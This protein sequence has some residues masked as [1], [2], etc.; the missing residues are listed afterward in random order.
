MSAAPHP[1]LTAFGLD[2]HYSA[3]AK[4]LAHTGSFISGGA[5]LYWKLIL[6]DS[7]VTVPDDMDIDIWITNSPSTD[8]RFRCLA[9]GHFELVLGAA[10]YV[11]Q[12]R[13]EHADYMSFPGGNIITYIQNFFHHGLKRNIQIIAVSSPDF[14]ALAGLFDLDICKFILVP[15]VVAYN[16]GLIS[17]VFLSHETLLDLNYTDIITRRVMTPSYLP[18]SNVDCCLARVEKY[19]SRGWAFEGVAPACDHWGHCKR[20]KIRLPLELARELVRNL[21][22]AAN[23]TA[24]GS[25]GSTETTVA[26]RGGSVET[27]GTTGGDTVETI[28]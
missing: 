28:D 7:S 11:R 21:V 3:F 4:A 26:T 13:H 6:Q 20:D 23:S 9:F 12:T 10:G 17:N 5:A 16:N 22:S 8:D 24:T 2:A 27:V 18:G 25:S 19:Y 15:G 14:S 1:I